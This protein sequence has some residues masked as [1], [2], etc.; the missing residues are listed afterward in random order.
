MVIKWQKHDEHTDFG[1][2]KVG[3]VIDTAARGIPDSVVGPWVRDGYALEAK[4]EPEVAAIK[5]AKKKANR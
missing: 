3:D 5:P 2:F 1:L 4:P